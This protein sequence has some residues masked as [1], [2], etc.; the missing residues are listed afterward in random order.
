[1]SLTPEVGRGRIGS[2]SINAALDDA[3]RLDTYAVAGL[4]AASLHT[5]KLVYVSNGASGS[6]CLAYSNGTSWLRVLIGA[7]VAAS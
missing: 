6:P 5:G 3:V 1:M 2:A 4:P 7:A